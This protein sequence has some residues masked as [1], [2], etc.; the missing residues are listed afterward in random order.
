[1]KELREL[2]KRA[3]LKDL[4]SL[5]GHSR[6]AYYCWERSELESALEEAIILDLVHHIRGQIPRIGT[7]AL[8]HLL[9]KQWER[10]G[11]KCGRDRLFSILGE[12]QLLIQPKRKYTQTTMSRHYLYKYPNLIKGLEPTAS[13]QL[14]VSDITY[15]R[16]DQEWN[17]VIFITDAYSHKVVGYKVDDNMKTDMCVQALEMA[18]ATRSKVNQDLVHHSDRGLQYCSKAY[19][20]CLLN[21]PKV[22]ISMTENGDPLEN[23]VAE[24]V[25]GIFKNTFNMDQH[26]ESL[27]QARKRIAQMVEAYNQLRPH[28][29]CDMMTPDQ[30]HQ[31][32]GRLQKRW[33]T[34]HKKKG[35][36]QQI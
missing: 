31:C 27:E 9:Q 5:F 8:H 18:L 19:V 1:M 15:I 4:C 14:W 6:Q 21:Q 2:K 3:S 33:K 13:E 35:M 22:K 23:A 30:A 20:Q 28:S 17:Y 7:R 12:A 32:S 25:N 11:I 10:Q 16:V 24:R 36:A 29:S 34:Y 26:F